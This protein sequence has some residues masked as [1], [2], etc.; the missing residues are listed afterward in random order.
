[1]GYYSFYNLNR[2]KMIRNILTLEKAINNIN[3]KIAE[4]NKNGA[5]LSFL[6]IVNNKWV[7]Q[8]KTYLI[9]KCN[10]HNVT[11]T[12]TSYCNFINRFKG[13][14]LC[15]KENNNLCKI[16]SKEDAYNI[17][18]NIHKDDDIKYN[19]EP[20][21]N[22]FTNK[23][24]N[25]SVICPKHG[26]FEIKY[27]TLLI[28]PNI[29]KC[30]ICIKE[31]KSKNQ[32]INVIGNQKVLKEI[33]NKLNKIKQENNIS[34]Q[35]LGFVDENIK[36]IISEK[37]AKLVLKCNIHNVIWNTTTLDNFLSSAD[38]IFCPECAKNRSSSTSNTERK[39]SIILQSLDSTLE[40]NRH[41]K[42]TVTD[43][44]CNKERLIIPD[45]YL[46][47]LNAIIEY[48]GE[49]H[50]KFIE[51]YHKLDYNYYVDRIN[52]D[53]CLVQYCKENN[54]R[55]LRIPWKDNNRLEEVI[56][57]FLVE[58]KDITTKVEPKLLPAVIIK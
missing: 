48:D 11:W 27:R 41:L 29:G 23:G 31:N 14:K 33:N 20:I 32:I 8:H 53:N 57:A 43:K 37:E 44:I 42:L 39:C 7:G 28:G 30:P 1:M 21:K 52:R 2:I 34:I 17:V 4:L 6:G 50:Y 54:I 26:K 9:L 56:K 35:F 25:V 12:S 15:N 46:P 36:N 47:S 18:L 24:N 55:L 5:N 49:Q 45:I 13:C 51:K 19:Y 10:I 16:N 3:D 38:G 22:T 58:G 40:I